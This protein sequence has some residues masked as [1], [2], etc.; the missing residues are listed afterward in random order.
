[1]PATGRS[2]AFRAVQ[3]YAPASARHEVRCCW[4]GAKRRLVS[5]EKKKRG[6]EHR[7]ASRA[8]GQE[9]SINE[10]KKCLVSWRCPSMAFVLSNDMVQECPENVT[11]QATCHPCPFHSPVAPAVMERRY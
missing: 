8:G 9:L 6:V 3:Q 4:K 2:V 5:E 1:M 11:G 7:D 10:L